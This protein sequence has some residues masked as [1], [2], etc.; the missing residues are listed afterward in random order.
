MC[1][2][3]ALRQIHVENM[4]ISERLCA[5]ELREHFLIGA[6][7]DTPGGCSSSDYTAVLWFFKRGPSSGSVPA[8][9]LAPVWMQVNYL[10]LH[11]SRPP[12]LHLISYAKG[13]TFGSDGVKAAGLSVPLLAPSVTSA[14]CEYTQHQTYIYI[15][16]FWGAGGNATNEIAA[17]SYSDKTQP[18]P[19]GWTMEE[20]AACRCDTFLILLELKRQQ[21]LCEESKYRR[22]HKEKNVPVRN[23]G[24]LR[25][26]FLQFLGHVKRRPSHQ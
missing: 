16:H 24:R 14:C 4:F 17:E 26:F 21:Q 9:W 7:C 5:A 1:D 8:P 3:S 20:A 6:P 19:S 25:R 18:K 12:L 13:V 10:P 22:R 11:V 23:G 15:F 2:A